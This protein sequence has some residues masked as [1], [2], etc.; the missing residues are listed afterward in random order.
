MS[1]TS[2]QRANVVVQIALGEEPL[3]ITWLVWLT[4]L[5]P[6]MVARAV[7][8]LVMSGEAIAVLGRGY[9]ARLM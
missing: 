2:E 7:R 9:M 1:T 8:R 4:G 3:S 6:S 5:P